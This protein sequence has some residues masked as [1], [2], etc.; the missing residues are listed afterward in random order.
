MSSKQFKQDENTSAL[1]STQRT[2][3]MVAFKTMA[4][5]LVYFPPLTC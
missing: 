2:I 1:Q 3:K 5:T 4:T